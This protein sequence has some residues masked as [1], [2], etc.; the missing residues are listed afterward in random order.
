MFE[1]G[2]RHVFE[3]A[4][5]LTVAPSASGLGKAG[6]F[7]SPFVM[8]QQLIAINR[9]SILFSQG[10]YSVVVRLGNVVLGC[11]KLSSVC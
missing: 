11:L 1:V 10:G 6:S 4:W 5:F 8:S 2:H 9:R 7:S 3:E